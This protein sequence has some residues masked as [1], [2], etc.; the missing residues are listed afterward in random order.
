MICFFGDHQPRVENDFLETLYGGAFDDL[1]SRMLK[2]KVPFFIW[3]NYDIDEQKGIETSINYLSSHLL[4]ACGLA[5]PSYN[6]FLR[7]AEQ[8]IPV[9]TAN[10]Y[11]SLNA[12]HF[13]PVSVATGEEKEILDSYHVLEYNNL[14]DKGE[15]SPIFEIK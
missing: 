9:L 10:G 2:Y 8:R 13:L 4:N 12:G 3:A 6:Q 7:D 14:F 1:D 15:E 11:F 5:L